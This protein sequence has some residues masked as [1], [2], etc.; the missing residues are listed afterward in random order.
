MAAPLPISPVQ[1]APD[2]A[3]IAYN[4]RNGLSLVSPGGQSTRVLHEQAWM[5]FT[6]S[7]D[8]QRVYGIRQSDAFQHLTFTSVDVRSG[9]ERVLEP[10]F[11][12]LPVSGQPVRGIARMSP[13]T[14]LASIEHVRSDVW[15]LEGFQP[16]QTL[17]DRLASAIPF[18]NH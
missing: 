14:F 8:G 4:G 2:G 3:W 7:A 16:P 13:T 1:W 6:W 18:R 17:W 9:A 15:L 5:A 12:P 11:M 10:D